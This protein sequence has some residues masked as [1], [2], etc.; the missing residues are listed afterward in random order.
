[1]TFFL[2]QHFSLL[3]ERG[4]HLACRQWHAVNDSYGMT[5]SLILL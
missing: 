2:L 4:S 3:P 1:M 5:T